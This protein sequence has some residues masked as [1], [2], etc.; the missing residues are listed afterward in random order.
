MLGIHFPEQVA[1]KIANLESYS[2]K[3][4]N[5]VPINKFLLLTARIFFGGLHIQLSVMLEYT[6]QEPNCNHFQT[7]FI[8]ICVKSSQ[9]N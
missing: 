7:I 4:C 2:T 1:K 5:L 6:H 3:C 9:R 8:C